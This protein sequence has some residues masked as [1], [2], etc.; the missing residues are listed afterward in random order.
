MP[1]QIEFLFTIIGSTLY[2]FEPSLC[3]K[4]ALKFSLFCEQLSLN[5]K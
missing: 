5:I 3:H 2:I 4:T 1:I